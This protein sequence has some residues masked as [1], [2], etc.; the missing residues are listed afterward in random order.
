MSAMEINM[1]CILSLILSVIF[2][3]FLL[4]L[5]YDFIERLVFVFREVKNAR[6]RK[7]TSDCEE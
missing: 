7:E 3:A 1:V 6:R 2:G 4:V 5:F